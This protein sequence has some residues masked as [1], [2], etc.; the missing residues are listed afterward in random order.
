[1]TLTLFSQEVSQDANYVFISCTAV[2]LIARLVAA[3]YQPKPFDPS[4]FIVVASLCIL[5]ARSVTNELTV[6]YGTASDAVT[7][8]KKGQPFSAAKLAHVKTGTVLSLTTRLLETSFWW[9]QTVL[10]LLLYRRLVA[11][12]AWTKLAA[13]ATWVFLGISYLGVVVTIFTECHPLHLY[14][15]VSPPPGKCVKAYHTTVVQSGSLIILDIALMIIASPV[16]FVKGGRLAQR[17]RIAGLFALGLLCTV[18]SSLRMAYIFS[19]GSA[20]ATRSFW[21][22]VLV[23]VSA[24][25]ANAPIIYGSITLLT[26][27]VTS[28]A[29]G[30]KYNNSTGNPSRFT[31]G[32]AGKSALETQVKV[33]QTFVVSSEPPRRDSDMASGSDI[34]LV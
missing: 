10:L 22:G 34:E 16:L 15:Q 31:R 20:Q 28:S 19:Q 25:V 12:I 27:G 23:L 13:K 33:T 2:I 7:A 8:A 24:F 6:Q 1:M 32:T 11:H 3:R 21:A 18:V 14:W 17:I 9:L 26:K 30:S 5:V 29:G 4:F